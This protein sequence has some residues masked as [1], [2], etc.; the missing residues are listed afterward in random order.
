MENRKSKKEKNPFQRELIYWPIILLPW[1]FILSLAA[2]LGLRL[3]EISKV[4]PDDVVATF[5]EGNLQKK[6]R[7]LLF[8]VVHG[9]KGYDMYDRGLQA[10]TD[11]SLFV[12]LDHTPRDYVI[13][14]YGGSSLVAPTPEKSFPSYLESLLGEEYDDQVKVYNFGCPGYSSFDVRN[15]MSATLDEF[16]PDLLIVYSGHNDYINSYNNV[17]P[18]YFLFSK[19]GYLNSVVRISYSSF[20]IP[21]LTLLDLDGIYH[22]SEYEVFRSFLLDPLMNQGLQHLDILTVPEEPFTRINEDILLHFMSN[23]Q[24]MIDMAAKQGV[25]ILFATLISNLE[26]APH[27]IGG[28]AERLF[29]RGLEN[30]DYP[31]RIDLLR[32]ARDAD[33]FSGDIRA[34]SALNK[35]LCSLARPGVKVLDLERNLIESEFAFDFTSFVDYVHFKSHVQ[36]RIAQIISR[37]LKDKGLSIEG[38]GPAHARSESGKTDTK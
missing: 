6:V 13:C 27:G 30:Q 17:K 34:K 20:I 14:V 33:V 25:P 29:E 23:I 16:T 35:F 9:I 26:S 11:T 8:D 1:S 37:H 22:L 32:Q 19:Q 7:P 24:A 12:P 2:A 10:D 38:S 28:R 4:H 5:K 21:I 3:V 18:Y 31:K 36:M 15:R